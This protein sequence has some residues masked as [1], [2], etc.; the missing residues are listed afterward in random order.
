MIQVSLEGVLEEGKEHRRLGVFGE[1]LVFAVFHHAYNFR[2]LAAPELEMPADCLVDGSENLAGKFAIDDG[3]HGSLVFIVHGEGPAGQKC[4]P[5][6]AEI[7]GRDLEILGIGCGIRGPEIGGGVGEYV[8]IA[9]A[10]TERKPIGISHGS[11]ARDRCGGIEHALLHLHALVA[12]I[13]SH[14]QIGLYEH[15]VLRLNAVVA[16]ERT[17][18]AAHGDE[19]SG[20]Q[21]SANGDLQTQQHVAQRKAACAA[22]ASGRRSE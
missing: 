12:V 17:R 5:G 4:G 1:G 22:D 2:P 16:L 10:D 20:D 13:S 9:A 3:D 21:N 6:G 14:L 19:R 15:H 8:G 11:D 7:I 18:Q